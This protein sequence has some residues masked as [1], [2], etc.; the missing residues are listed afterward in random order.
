[1]IYDRNPIRNS[2]GNVE[3]LLMAADLLPEAADQTI[4]SWYTTKVFRQRS[5][6]SILRCLL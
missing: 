1:L 3:Q 4:R 6:S 5:D 2:G